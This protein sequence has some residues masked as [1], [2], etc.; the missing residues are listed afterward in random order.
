MIASFI[1][2]QARRAVHL[3][4]VLFGDPGRIQSSTFDSIKNEA[5]IAGALLALVALGLAILISS[6]IAYEPGKNP[7]DPR[8][9]LIVFII[10]GLV[11]V[12]A[13]FAISTFTPT[14]LK[15]TQLSEF[16]QTM[17]ISVV[18]NALLYFVLGFALSKMLP[19]TK[20]GTWFPSK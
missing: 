3:W 12:V 16:R 15:G 18:I 2:L 19:K 9:R 20:I 8:K 13:L 14:V 6:L 11:T 5:F 4:D 10:I 17:Y 7:K 1:I